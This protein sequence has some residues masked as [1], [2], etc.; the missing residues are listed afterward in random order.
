M[1][2]VANQTSKKSRKHLEK[3]REF[4]SSPI[5]LN[6]NWHSMGDVVNIQPLLPSTCPGVH[7]R[8]GQTA[9]F[10]FI[11]LFCW[12]SKTWSLRVASKPA[13]HSAIVASMISCTVDKLLH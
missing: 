13:V 9:Q 8:L 7:F 1:V 4:V 2:F 10:V 11:S 12:G 6:T 5:F 3:Y